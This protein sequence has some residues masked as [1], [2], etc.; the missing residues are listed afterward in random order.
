MESQCF[1]GL[2]LSFI[3]QSGHDLANRYSQ[4]LEGK[5]QMKEAVATLALEKEKL[6]NQN[7]ELENE[8]LRLKSELSQLKSQNLRV[9]S[10]T[11]AKSQQNLM[12]RKNAAAGSNAGTKRRRESGDDRPEDENYFR[13]DC[14]NNLTEDDVSDQSQLLLEKTPVRGQSK[15]DRVLAGKRHGWVSYVLFGLT[16]DNVLDFSTFSNF[17]SQDVVTSDCFR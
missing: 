2:T 6:L 15:L 7:Q 16:K 11:K 9:N 13:L 12:K 5:K 14:M 3:F 8:N 10:L 4:C 17:Y 1:I